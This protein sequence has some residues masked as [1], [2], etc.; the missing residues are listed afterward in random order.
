MDRTIKSNIIFFT[1]LLFA[2]KTLPFLA[3]KRGP[4]PAAASAPPPLSAAAAAAATI[5]VFSIGKKLGVEV[6]LEVL[7][8]SRV[9]QT[10]IF[11]VGFLTYYKHTRSRVLRGLND[12]VFKNSAAWNNSLPPPYLLSG[13]RNY[14]KEGQVFEKEN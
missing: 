10:A 7:E 4:P 6:F 11:G 13:P 9:N 3:L 2:G 1:S 8:E 12:A 5:S 14:G